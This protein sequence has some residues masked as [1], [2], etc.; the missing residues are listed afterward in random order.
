M[1]EYMAGLDTDKPIDVVPV[2]VVRDSM[3]ASTKMELNHFSETSA[4]N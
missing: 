3:R 4:D 2:L 1:N